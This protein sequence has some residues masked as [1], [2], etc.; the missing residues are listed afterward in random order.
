MQ[1]SIIERKDA[2]CLNN[3]FSSLLCLPLYLYVIYSVMLKKISKQSDAFY[4]KQSLYS[5]DL[6]F[7][8][9]DVELNDCFPF[10]SFKY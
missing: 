5:L 7:K 4:I 1:A 10:T 6:F 8:N 9:P 2:E 3:R